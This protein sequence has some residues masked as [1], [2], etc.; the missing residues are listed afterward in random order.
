MN[1]VSK[2][3]IYDVM[4]LIFSSCSATNNVLGLT[5]TSV[6]YTLDIQKDFADMKNNYTSIWS[7]LNSHNVNVNENDDIHLPCAIVAQNVI[8]TYTSE[9]GNFRHL[10]KKFDLNLIG[11]KI[12]QA[13]TY[14]CRDVNNS[15]HKR[16][17]MDSYLNKIIY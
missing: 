3:S 6:N 11:L 2:N 16:V 13:G 9:G 15:N 5:H 10:E 12:D 14:E 7:H 1:S 8:W 4:V 17:S